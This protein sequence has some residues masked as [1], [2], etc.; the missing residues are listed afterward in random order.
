MASSGRSAA[1]S[2]AAFGL[3]AGLG[4]GIGLYV[5][6]ESGRSRWPILFG[7]GPDVMWVAPIVDA[8]LFLL[9]AGVVVLVARALRR[10]APLALVVGLCAFALAADWARVTH[11]LPRRYALAIGATAALLAGLAARRREATLARAAPIAAGVLA[12]AT[13]LLALGV[14]GRA[15]LAES[16]AE[17]KLPPPP[18]SARDVVVVVLDTVR[19]DHLSAFGYARRTTPNLERLAAEGVRFDA[20]FSTSSWTLPAHASMLTGRLPWE[21]GA[22]LEPLD[23]TWPL[24]S[25]ELAAHGFRTGAFSGNLCFFQRGYGFGR[26]F[27]HFDDFDWSWRARLGSTLLARELIDRAGPR[28]R[29]LLLRKPARAVTDAFL[30]WLDHSP[31]P[32]FAFLNWFDAHCPYHPPE[33][34]TGRFD[35]DGVTPPA[36]PIGDPAV[37]ARDAQSYDECILAMDAELGRLCDELRRRDRFDRTVLFVLSDHGEGFGEHE[38]RYHRGSLYREQVQVPF[39]VHAPGLVPTGTTIDAVASLASLPAT[40]LDLLELPSGTFPGPSLAPLWKDG[41]AETPAV[42]EL[43]QHP[44]AEYKRRACYDGALRSIVRGRWH[45]VWHEKHG[46][47]LFDRVT[48]PAELHDVK[49]DHPDVAAA[50]DHQLEQELDARIRHPREPMTLDLADHPELAGIGYAA[51]G[52]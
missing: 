16:R 8:V 15:W 31:R 38:M 26:G 1:W 43:A 14:V 41:E 24:L 50:L 47:Q 20:C 34:F 36:V 5:A 7:T 13:L 40:V 42:L 25:E 6:Q 22:A 11:E 45:L 27:L 44:W 18:A 37:L 17:A 32:V 3:L 21:H 46:L 4:E 10:P 35:G 29:D 51:G 52:R 12:S 39:V 19:A 2:A 33:G 28:A 48:D 23:G 9:L 30:A 49:A